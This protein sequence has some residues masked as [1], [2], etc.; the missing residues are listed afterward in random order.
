MNKK[1]SSF[2]NRFQLVDLELLGCNL[3]IHEQKL[4]KFKKGTLQALVNMI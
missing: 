3:I 1:I 4:K 2:Y